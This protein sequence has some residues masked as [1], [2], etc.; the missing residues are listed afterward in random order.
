MKNIQIQLILR[1][2]TLKDYK[3]FLSEK[4]IELIVVGPEKPLAFGIADEFEKEGFKVFGPRKN[5]AEIES[6][7]IFA[8]R[9]M[10][11][12]NIPTASFREFSRVS[13]GSGKRVS[14]GL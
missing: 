4:N 6:S 8:K 13:I 3:S 2:I 5:A 10:M 14:E 12:Y 1:L 9:L 7:K 11:K